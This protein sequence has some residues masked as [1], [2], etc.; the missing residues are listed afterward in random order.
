MV[1]RHM[2]E[3]KDLEIVEVNVGRQERL[4]V[5]LC[6]SG[7]LNDREDVTVP[8]KVFDGNR[9]DTF[10][11]QWVSLNE[12]SGGELIFHVII[13]QEVEN[14]KKLSNALKTLIQSEAMGYVSGQIL[15]RTILAGIMSSLAP[16]ALLR[17][18][19]IMGWQQLINTVAHALIH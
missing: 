3:V 4:G 9:N 1:E 10:A 16:L 13:W 17:F 2:K 15:R 11:L 14:L 18:G 8:W 12:M 19:Q 6:V 5:N 7:W